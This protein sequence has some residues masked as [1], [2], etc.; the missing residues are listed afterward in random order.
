LKK[1]GEIDT[2]FVSKHI[3]KEYF[4]SIYDGEKNIGLCPQTVVHH[5]EDGTVSVSL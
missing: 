2:T 3:N 1:P 4:L 5:Y